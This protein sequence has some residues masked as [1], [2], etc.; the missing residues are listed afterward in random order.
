MANLIDLLFS[1]NGR[2]SRTTFWFGT[3]IVAAASI[4]GALLIDPS[5]FVLDLDLELNQ[6][7]PRTPNWAD[8]IWQLALVIPGTALLVKRFNDRDRPYWLG[9]AFGAAG[10]AL[11]IAPKFG[12]LIPG[13]TSRAG[14]IVLVI[15][16]L[17][18]FIA[19]IDTGLLR[20]THGPN[21][22]GSDPLAPNG[23][24]AP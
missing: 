14:T 18:F 9:Y 3:F 20:G 11:T 12:L 10:A 15:V 8:T 1:F 2:M 13:D 24:Q 23:T 21:R 16:G 6:L 4:A 7:A 17:A 19:S 22:Y 5:I